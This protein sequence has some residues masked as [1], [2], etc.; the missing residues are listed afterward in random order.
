VVEEFPS[1]WVRKGTYEPLHPYSRFLFS[2]FSGEA[3]QQLR[4]EETSLNGI[5][6]NGKAMTN[7]CSNGCVY[8][9][10]CDLHKELEEELQRKCHSVHPDLSEV[11]ESSRVACWGAEENEG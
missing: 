6:G 8:T 3:F 9:H 10:R 2:M 4:Q 11:R 5:P 1:S 7:G